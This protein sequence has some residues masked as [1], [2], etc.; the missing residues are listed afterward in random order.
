MREN[1]FLD[2]VKKKNEEKSYE[3]FSFGAPEGK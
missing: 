3:L 1:I 2:G